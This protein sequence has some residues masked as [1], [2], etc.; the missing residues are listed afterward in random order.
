MLI[1]DSVYLLVF[2]LKTWMGSL[3]TLI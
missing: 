1:M 3:M 2:Q